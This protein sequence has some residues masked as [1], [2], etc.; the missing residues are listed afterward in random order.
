MPQALNSPTLR[1]PLI[2]FAHRILELEPDAEQERQ[3]TEEYP[4]YD[5]LARHM[6]CKDQLGS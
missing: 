3:L 6:Q 5:S 4:R 1:W 2:G